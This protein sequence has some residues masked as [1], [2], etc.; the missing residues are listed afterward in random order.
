ME[1]MVTKR[2]TNILESKN[3][4]SNCQ[5]GYKTRHSSIDA[6][7]RIENSIRY[8]F[9]RAEHCLAVFLDISNAFDCVNHKL[10]MNKILQLG[11]KGNMGMFV[12]DFLRGRTL[13]VRV[14]NVLPKKTGVTCGVPQGS[15]ISPLLFSIMINDI[16]NDLEEDQQYSLYADDGAMWLTCV[17]V[18]QGL[19]KLQEAINTVDQ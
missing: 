15:V 19:R 7:C 17:E 8:S 2:F 3:S 4:I 14:G 10:V 5:S 1:R 18:E 12:N 11:I 13:E 6:I 9:M 16:F